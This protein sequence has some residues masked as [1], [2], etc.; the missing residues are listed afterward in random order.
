MKRNCVMLLLSRIHAAASLTAPAALSRLDRAAADAS[1]AEVT[2]QS[3][4]TG[5]GASADPAYSTD[6]LV[7]ATNPESHTSVSADDLSAATFDTVTR[8]AAWR[9]PRWPT[10]NGGWTKLKRG[11]DSLS[12]ATDSSRSSTL[13][14]CGAGSC[15]ADAASSNK[16]SSIAAAARRRELP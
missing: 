6:V 16:G 7:E 1:P 12:T 11:T 4:C 3:G 15:S 13:S 5:K 2:R 9:T 14:R 8:Y 10:G